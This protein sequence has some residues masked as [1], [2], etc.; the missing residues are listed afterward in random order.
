MNWFTWRDSWEEDDPDADVSKVVLCWKGVGTWAEAFLANTDSMA[1]QTNR[2][3][4]VRQNVFI[5]S[6][7]SVITRQAATRRWCNQA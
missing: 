4:R 5:G 1:M 3:N 2:L 6:P 7:V